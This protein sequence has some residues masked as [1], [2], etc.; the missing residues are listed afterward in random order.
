VRDLLTGGHVRD[1]DRHREPPTF[2]VNPGT[3]VDGFVR[4]FIGTPAFA[5]SVTFQDQRT[6]TVQQWKPR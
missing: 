2:T 4:V 5:G 6:G 3:L 1:V